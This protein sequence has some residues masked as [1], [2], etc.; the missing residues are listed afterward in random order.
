MQNEHTSSV[1]KLAKKLIESLQGQGIELKNTQALEIISKLQNGSDWNRLSAKLRGNTLSPGKPK[2][3]AALVM[4][5]PPGY[6]KSEAMRTLFE[7]ECI[8]GATCPLYISL[9]GFAHIS[10][11]RPSER[12]AFLTQKDLLT[13]VYDRS[14][15][16]S[17]NAVLTTPC[18]VGTGKGV[19]VNLVANDR[20]KS[21]EGIAVTLVQ[22]LERLEQYLPGSIANQIGSVLIDDYEMYEP[23]H[24]DAALKAIGAFLQ[25]LPTAR[26]LVIS[27]QIALPTSSLSSLGFPLHYV[28]SPSSIDW[29]SNDVSKVL[30]DQ[31]WS[32]TSINDHAIVSD[33][34]WQSVNTVFHRLS[35][36][37]HQNGQSRLHRLPSASPWF[38]DLKKA[39]A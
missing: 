10:G 2:N 20:I 24:V 38:K 4:V 23:K 5:A 30:K 21:E 31:S 12:D 28:V 26:R 13:V 14:G 3:L 1:K 19:L 16:V 33:L 17:V 29:Y 32:S 7:I 6:G 9:T 8:D 18:R 39:L 25:R 15:I 36:L 11:N 35:Y 22:L 37:Y 34:Y 27:S